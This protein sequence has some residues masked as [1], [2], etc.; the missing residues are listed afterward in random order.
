MTTSITRFPLPPGVPTDAIKVGFLEVAPK[1]RHPAGLV[2]KYFLLA[3][4]GTT[5][6]GVYLWKSMQDAR[7]FSERLLRPMIRE[8]FRV[9]PSIEY[10]DVPVIVDNVTS[11]IIG[12]S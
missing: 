1:F 8:K 5:A 2:R 7:N 10:F 12:G 6:G 11:E 3:E 4:D 9:E